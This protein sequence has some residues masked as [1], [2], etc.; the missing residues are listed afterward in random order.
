MI[1][2]EVQEKEFDLA[3]TKALEE[4]NSHAQELILELQSA[5]IAELIERLDE[6]LQLE[7][8]K[9]LPISIAAEVSTFLP[10]ELRQEFWRESSDDYLAELLSEMEPDDRRFLLEAIP[11]ERAIILL[12]LIESSEKQETEILLSYPEGSVGRLMTPYFVKVR[13]HWNLEYV[14]R[15]IRKYGPSAET[16]EVLYVIDRTGVL[17]DDIPVREVLLGDPESTVES[18]MNYEFISI[19]AKED[20][21][22]ALRLME[23]YDI[24]VL[25]VLS[26][27]NRLL[28]IVTTDDLFDVA[29]QEASEDIEKL[30]GMEAL[31][32]R[33]SGVSIYRLF[34]KR[35]I[36]LLGLFA[37]GLLTVVAMGPFQQKIEKEAIL[38]LFVPL[39]IASG[40][41]TGTQAASLMIRA[42]ALSDV[43]LKDW[44]WVMKRELTNGL[45]LAGVLGVMGFITGYS[46]SLMMSGGEMNV[47]VPLTLGMAIGF[48]VAIMVISGSLVGSMLPFIFGRMGI[49]PATSSTP[50]V[51]TILDVT[52][53]IVY[54]TVAGLILGF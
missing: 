2:T 7:A 32:D 9:L 37:G 16:L 35:V 14:L 28:G 48:A 13:P 43:T 21:E 20:Q 45:L 51:A 44:F 12:S 25:P 36:W 27:G 1:G 8:F 42:L 24:T 18:L 5:D 49:D 40:G 6:N 15:Y 47:P 41:N 11:E 10:Q 22:L 31:G 26:D 4:G 39:I 53:V 33:Y 3:L 50:A 19:H 17:I 23:K 46:A 34:R 52:G 30:G 29:E 54:F 38:A